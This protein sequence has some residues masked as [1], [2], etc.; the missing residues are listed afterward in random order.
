MTIHM[1][2][3]HMGV[4]GSERVC[5]NLANEFVKKHEVHIV[6]LNLENDVNSHLL[7]KRV[8]VHEL[9]VSRL[10]YAAIPMISYI[11]KNKP[12]F[13]FVFGN[14]MAIII[15]KLKKIKLVNT[16]VVVRVLNN[17]NIS[18]AKEDN[19]SPVVENYLKAAQKQMADMDCVIAQCKA[20]GKMILEKKL[21]DEEQLKV[22]Y[23][24]V[25]GGL[26][27]KVD[28]LRTDAFAKSDTNQ[29]EDMKL[30]LDKYGT[31]GNRLTFIGR[32][33]PQKQPDQLIKTFALVLKAKP[34]VKLRIVGDG[35]LMEQT[36]A[37][38]EE[39]GVGDS[40]VFDGIRK[41]MENVYANTD[42][43]ILSSQY[44]GMP[45]ALIEAI[46]CGIPIVSYDCPIG[47][48]EIIEDGV[49][50]YLVEQDNIEQLAGKTVLALEQSWDRDI[51]KAT[52]KKFDVKN[53]AEKYIEIFEAL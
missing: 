46:G 29:T 36:K 10:R 20:M 3:A 48:A 38:I 18:L 50:G 31:P 24:P 27:E 15:N 43:V 32:V 25:S 9:G 7:D 22:I 12:K 39:L 23:N 53:I 30:L 5:V 11:K 14:E 8:K 44:E 41:D 37:L 1:F 16:K 42:V 2:L 19:V 51:I 13:M 35:N 47:P 40:I 26:I 21:V 6:V 49:N 52:C 45:N 33:D 28:A 34:D 17:V 4:G